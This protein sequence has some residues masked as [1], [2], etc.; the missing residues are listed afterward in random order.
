MRRLRPQRAQMCPGALNQ[1]VAQWPGA[2]LTRP[3]LCHETVSGDKPWGGPEPARAACLVPPQGLLPSAAAASFGH[4]SPPIRQLLAP[5]PREALSSPA[6]EG[7]CLPRGGVLWPGGMSPSPHCQ[8]GQLA[9]STGESQGS[10]LCLGSCKGPTQ[11]P[12]AG[13]SIWEQRLGIVQGPPAKLRTWE[14][15]RLGCWTLS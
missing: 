3:R 4:I 5:A 12:T 10:R 8:G 15:G 11:L 7:A 2:Q 14:T 6:G 9:I 1:D 13:F